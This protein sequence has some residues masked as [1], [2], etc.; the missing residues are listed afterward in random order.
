MANAV[1]PLYKSALEQGSANSAL[2]GTVKVVLI[3]LGAYTYNEAHQFYSDLT[4]IVGSPSPA[5]TNKSYVGGAFSADPVMLPGVQG[6]HI[7]ALII[8]IDTGTP[9]T[10]RLVFY[11]DTGVTGLPYTPTSPTDIVITWDA[12]ANKI[13]VL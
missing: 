11:Q 7:E 3:D 13:F 6:T 9:G 4:G 5:L 12:G 1:Y 10:S 8:F 2:T